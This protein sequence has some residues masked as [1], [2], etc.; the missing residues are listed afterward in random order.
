M[1]CEITGYASAEEY[2]SDGREHDLLFL[3]IELGKTESCI[4][5]MELAGLRVISF[6]M[7]GADCPGQRKEGRRHCMVSGFPMSDGKF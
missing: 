7:R 5:G 6:L 3:D 2:L 1:K 4:N